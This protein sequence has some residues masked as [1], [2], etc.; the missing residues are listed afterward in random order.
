VSAAFDRIR[1][2]LRRSSPRVGVTPPLSDWERRR[3][4]AE[5]HFVPWLEQ[6]ISLSGR[7]VLE[8][9]C[10][11]GCVS[12]A[13]GPRAGRYI[14]LDIDA[15]AVEDARRL[16]AQRGMEPELVAAPSSRILS[17][18]AAFRG[19]IDIFLCYAVL[20]H[21]SLDERLALLELARQVVRPTGVV[22]VVE[23]PNRLTPWDYHTSQLPFLYQL[24]E[25]LALRYYDRSPRTEFVDALRASSANGD[26]AVRETLTR[27]GRGVSYHEFE[28]IFG[29]LSRHVLASGWDPVLLPERNIYREELALQR[30]L[31]TAR[32]ELPPSFSRYWLDLVLAPEPRP[33]PARFVRP[34]SLR[35]AGSTSVAFD[36]SETLRMHAADAVLAVD[37]PTASARLVIEAQSDARRLEISVRQVANGEEE[38]AIASVAPDAPGHAEV[39][40]RRPADRYEVRIGGLGWITFVGYEA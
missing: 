34:W 11:N 20:E 13:F 23:T 2:R 27:W 10:G 26:E 1:A 12:A 38:R 6:V 18:T 29:D 7:T 31:D 5:R 37:L 17:E 40:F 15:G 25:E 28:L 35:T 22:V 24:P 14:G 8:Y 16:L 30:I 39:R 36:A 32:P 33:E 19:E 9:G 4:V 21:M 3:L